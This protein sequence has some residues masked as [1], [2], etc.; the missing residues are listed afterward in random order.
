MREKHERRRGKRWEKDERR[1][2]KVWKMRERRKGRRL[3]RRI[4]EGGQDPQD[5]RRWMRGEDSSEQNLKKDEEERRRKRGRRRKKEKKM[6]WHWV[7]SKITDHHSVEHDIIAHTGLNRMRGWEKKKTGFEEREGSEKKERKREER[8]KK[9][10][11][12]EA[13]FLLGAKRRDLWSIE[14]NTLKLRRVKSVAR[15][16]L[17]PTRFF[18]FSLYFS[19][20]LHIFSFFL[21]TLFLSFYFLSFS[22]RFANSE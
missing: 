12:R 8:E 9:K 1:R 14:K 13:D 22:F 18:S 11:V 21:Y 6:G 7:E 10:I 4:K 15:L 5:S 19:L 3:R 17:R 2:K 16:W 20:S